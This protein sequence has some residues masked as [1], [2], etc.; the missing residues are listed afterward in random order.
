MY[1]KIAILLLLAACAS[2]PKRKTK[3]K[4]VPRL[5][6]PTTG[7]YQVPCPK[8]TPAHSICTKRF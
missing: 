3:V 4:P 2:T 7:V 8:G 5:T 1:N 6:G